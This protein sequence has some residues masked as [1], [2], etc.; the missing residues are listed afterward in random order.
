V[1]NRIVPARADLPGAGDLGVGQAIEGTMAESVPLRRL[2]LDGLTEIDLASLR[3]TGRALP[4]LDEAAQVRV[5]ETVEAARPAL[6]AAL[7]DHTY[8]GYYTLPAVHAAIGYDS[9]PP[10]PLGHELPAFDLALL[11]RQRERTPFWR[12]AT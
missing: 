5:L 10:Q 9:R 7:V 3:L 1:L 4:E 2:F 6:F 12:R 8:R 11:D